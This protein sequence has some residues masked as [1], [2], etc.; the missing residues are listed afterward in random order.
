MTKL[1]FTA[2]LLS[3]VSLGCSPLLAQSTEAVTKHS[4]FYFGGGKSFKDGDR[5]DTST[6]FAL[7][8]THQPAGGQ[9]VW[10]LDIAREGTKYDST[11]WQNAT[12]DAAFSFN[13][14]VGRSLIDSRNVKIDAGVIL[15]VRESAE[16]CP[17]SYLGFRCYANQEPNTDYKFNGG[18]LAT[19]SLDRYVIGARATG[20]SGQVIVGFRF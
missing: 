2:A 1:T 12:I 15:G 13:L 3:A 10:G 14:V 7:G 4:T 19:L 16:E 5:E 6:P 8:F 11:G 17:G 18:V 9:V 20:E